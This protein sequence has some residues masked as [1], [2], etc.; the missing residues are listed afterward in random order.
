MT[1]KNRGVGRYLSDDHHVASVLRAKKAQ[2]E[3]DERRRAHENEMSAKRS[4]RQSERDAEADKV[5]SQLVA[6][7]ESNTSDGGSPLKSAQRRE[8]A[9]RGF[10]K[11]LDQ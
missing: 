9:G 11:Y 7:T 10:G 5:K 1:A 8:N 4:K 6:G 3:R 2:L